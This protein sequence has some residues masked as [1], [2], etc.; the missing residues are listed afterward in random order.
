MAEIIKVDSSAFEACISAYKNSLQTLQGA[1]NTYEQAL[2]ALQNDW[3]GRA[4]AIMCGKVVQMVS[5]I[6]ASFERVTDAI[7]ELQEAEKMF[8]NTENSIKS[9]INS[10]DAGSKSPF[11]A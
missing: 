5:K 6:R 9:R 3:T 1:V 7:N 10:L 8:V 4:F 11:G 2:N